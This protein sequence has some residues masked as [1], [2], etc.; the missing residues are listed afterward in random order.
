MADTQET[1]PLII[2]SRVDGTPVF[3]A[4]G[5]QIGHITDLSIEK[6]SGKV[7]YALVSFGG[8]LGIGERF[9]PLPWDELKYNIVRDGYV[10][11]LSKAELEKAPTY[12]AEQLATFGGLDLRYRDALFGY[13]E[14]YGALPY[15]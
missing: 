1:H 10:I 11:A 6:T 9:H 3:N 12:N 7:I 5:E 8:F 14:P 4:E 2:A 15:W 13:Y